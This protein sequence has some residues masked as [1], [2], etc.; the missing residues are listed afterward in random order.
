MLVSQLQGHRR[1]KREDKDCKPHQLLN[2]S[3]A[4]TAVRVEPQQKKARLEEESAKRPRR[5]ESARDSGEASSS[6]R[7][8]YKDLVE[9]RI[10]KVQVGED[11]MY[12]L[13]EVID[14]ETIEEDVDQFDT[15]DKENHNRRGKTKW[16]RTG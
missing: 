12:H 2:I 6:G 3:L 15:N 13:G 16:R 7:D 9:R 4:R 5:G 10:E 11:E 1:D 8:G 14:V